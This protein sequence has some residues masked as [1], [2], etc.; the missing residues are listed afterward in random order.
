MSSRDDV[1]TITARCT[2]QEGAL[3]LVYEIEKRLERPPQALY[4]LVEA[5]GTWDKP[6]PIDDAVRDLVEAVNPIVEIRGMTVRKMLAAMR[7]ATSH[8]AE[9]L[10]RTRVTVR[11]K[12]V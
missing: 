8:R 11:R 5:L 9:A 10:R 3:E 2:T 4:R 12:R 7:A 6:V 1:K